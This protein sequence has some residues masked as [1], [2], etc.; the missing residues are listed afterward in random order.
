[1]GEPVDFQ[2][3][4]SIWSAMPQEQT[5]DEQGKEIFPFSISPP[6]LGRDG[7]SFGSTPFSSSA[8]NPSSVPTGSHSLHA[9]QY[10][11]TA[12]NGSLEL[13]S[14]ALQGKTEWKKFQCV[15]C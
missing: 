10:V 9:K 8:L 11:E 2:S 13:R 7:N 5:K 15:I 1:M 12:L 3:A 6:L 4:S 14:E